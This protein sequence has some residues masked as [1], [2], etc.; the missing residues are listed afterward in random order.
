MPD[1]MIAEMHTRS[2]PLL[3]Q[4]VNRVPAAAPIIRTYMSEV[5]RTLR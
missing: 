3:E 2:R 1:A 5:R 4:Y